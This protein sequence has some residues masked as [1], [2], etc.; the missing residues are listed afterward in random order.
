MV[1]IRPLQIV[2]LEKFHLGL[3]C[4]APL[5]QRRLF[6]SPSVIGCKMMLMTSTTLEGYQVDPSAELF[7]FWR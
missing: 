1:P 7:Q 5:L 3:P 2:K 6:T 4:F